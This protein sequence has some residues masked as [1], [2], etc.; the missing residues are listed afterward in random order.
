MSAKLVPTSADIWCRVVRA[1]DP[2]L[3]FLDPEPLFFPSSSSS[4]ILMKLSGPS[5]SENLVVP[6]IETRISGSVA[7][8][9]D[10]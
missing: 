9:S 2:N 3:G 1:T 4:V 5:I 6:G 7:S 10:H 8:N